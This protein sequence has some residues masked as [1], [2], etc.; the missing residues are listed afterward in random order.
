[1][2]FDQRYTTVA[3]F[4]YQN[5]RLLYTPI[6]LPWQ[7]AT[8]WLCVYGGYC[9]HRRRLCQI[10]RS[11]SLWSS[12]D[13]LCAIFLPSFV[14]YKWVIYWFYTSDF[15]SLNSMLV[16]VQAVIWPTYVWFLTFYTL[17]LGWRVVLLHSYHIFLFIL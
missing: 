17:L 11:S 9:V 1:M 2:N 10:T 16:G 12:C 13:S 4:F 14:P 5:S 6:N 3:F 15:E 8:I 7:I